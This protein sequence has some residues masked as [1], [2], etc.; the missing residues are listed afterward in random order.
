MRRLE[1]PLYSSPEYPETY[2]GILD[3][4]I[5]RAKDP[6]KQVLFLMSGPDIQVTYADFGRNVNK[7]CNMLLDLGIKK[8][9]HVAIFIPNC[10]E[11]AYLFL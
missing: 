11:Y 9:D 10:L 8:G 1:I 5:K 7:I 2:S 6:E 3:W 4:A